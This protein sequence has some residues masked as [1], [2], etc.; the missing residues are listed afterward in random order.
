MPKKT[1]PQ[2][3]QSSLILIA[4]CVIL[5]S[6]VVLFIVKMA[7]PK[8][9]LAPKPMDQLVQTE[10]DSSTLFGGKTK[11]EWKKTLTSKQFSILHEKGTEVP[12][13][14]EYLDNKKKGVYV[15]A[16]CEEPVFS[17]EQKYESNTGWPSFYAP[18]DEDAVILREDNDHGQKRIEVIGKKCGT[19]LG[20][21]FDDGP[22]PTGK[23]YCINSAALKFIPAE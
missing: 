2:S 17:S 14:G 18:I 22:E 4:S 7:F 6:L 20:H 3:T 16:D 15:T 12:F 5:L 10:S 23:R 8:K 21:V 13:T 9:A 11:E 1:P 19:H